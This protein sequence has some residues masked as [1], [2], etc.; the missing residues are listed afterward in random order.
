MDTLNEAAARAGA[1][2]MIPDRTLA[3]ISLAS[4]REQQGD[5]EE[6]ARI[7]AEAL[8]ASHAIG[9]DRFIAMLEGEPASLA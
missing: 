3:M 9:A 1:A 2:G 6:A 8:T 5:V 4:V 7:R